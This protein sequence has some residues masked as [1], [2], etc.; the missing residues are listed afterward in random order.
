MDKPTLDNYKLVE[1][2]ILSFKK[3]N[4][5]IWLSAIVLSTVTFVLFIYILDIVDKD[6]THG[7]LVLIVYLGLLINCPYPAG[8]YIWHILLTSLFRRLNKKFDSYHRYNESIEQYQKEWILTQSTFWISLSPKQFELAVAKIFNKMGY[9]AKVTDYVG[10]MG[11]DIWVTKNKVQ[12]PVQCK[13]HKNRISPGA[14]RELYGTMISFGSKKGF[15]VS[16]SGFT[17]GVYEFCSTK[18]IEL[19]DLNILISTQQKI[20]GIQDNI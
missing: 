8:A 11:V 10:D 12:Y 14:A 18:P 15:L 2:D 1:S 20:S 5:W 16:R 9:E 17:K 4:K 13:A 7:L 6:N 19:I 3:I